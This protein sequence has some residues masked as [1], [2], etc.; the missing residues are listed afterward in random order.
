MRALLLLPL[1]AAGAWAAADVRTAARW[2]PKEVGVVVLGPAGGPEWLQTA[3]EL[4][5]ALGPGVPLEAALGP[6]GTRSL[7]QAL[8]RLQQARV[9][10]I[11]VLPFFLDT[12]SPDVEQAKYV[13]GIQEYPSRAFMT[14]KHANLGQTR[15]RRAL[16]KAPLVMTTA[17]DGD[18]AAVEALLA[19]AKPA[20]RDPRSE[21]VILA[22]RGSG[23]RASDELTTRRMSEAARALQ[24]S[25]GFRVAVGALLLPEAEQAQREKAAQALR[26]LVR[27]LSGG[28]RV[29]VLPY[30]LTQDGFERSLKRGLDGLFCKVQ[31]KAM[32]PH[33]ALARWAA[34][35]LAESR[36]LPD[37]VRFKDAAGRAL[38]PPERKR[39]VK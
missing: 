9:R 20:S 33:P 30:A 7:Q 35:K 38:P 36:D 23:D 24:K 26:Q 29:I 25:G 10:R 28:G 1:A 13:L 12:E 5:K 4:Q 21:A 11:V 8:D 17:L 16:A 14:R 32:L 39:I 37:M 2:G 6:P 27:S 19:A 18:P 15:V 34:R 3:K 31:E 22:G